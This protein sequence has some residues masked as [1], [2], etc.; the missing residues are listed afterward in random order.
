[1]RVLCTQ[2]RVLL[3]NDVSFF[4]AENPRSLLH[5]EIQFLRS[6]SRTDLRQ[7]LSFDQAKG[8][9]CLR[10]QTIYLST[11]PINTT[12]RNRKKTKLDSR[13]TSPNCRPV[14]N[15][16]SFFQILSANSNSV[17]RIFV[18]VIVRYIYCFWV[19]V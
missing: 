16:C 19:S 1:M 4:G 2:K 10:G 13:K 6:N 11:K 15:I 12:T 5:N 8:Y 18:W 9:Q 7:S 3:L 14:F 17:Y